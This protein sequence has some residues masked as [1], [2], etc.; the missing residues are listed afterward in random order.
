M[1]ESTFTLPFCDGM[2]ARCECCELRERCEHELHGRMNDEGL[3]CFQLLPLQHVD[4]SER[5]AAESSRRI[6]TAPRRLFP[7]FLPFPC[8]GSLN[9]YVP[10]L[11]TCT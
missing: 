8:L 9:W 6:A 5:R 1:Q 3:T 2:M 4:L 7:S 11:Y 10:I